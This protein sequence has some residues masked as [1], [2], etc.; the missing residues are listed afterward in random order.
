[1]SAGG[2]VFRRCPGYRRPPNVFL[3]TETGREITDT[4]MSDRDVTQ[5]NHLFS[6]MQIETFLALVASPFQPVFAV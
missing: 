5:T 1:M 6:Y 2:I 3:G 4:V